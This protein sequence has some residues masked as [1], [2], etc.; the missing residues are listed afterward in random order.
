MLCYKIIHFVPEFPN[1][2]S[3]VTEHNMDSNTGEGDAGVNTGTNKEC[4]VK[5]RW[6]LQ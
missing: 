2:S 1:V 5:T 4:R 3:L 6:I